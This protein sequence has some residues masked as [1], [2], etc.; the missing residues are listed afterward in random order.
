MKGL[1]LGRMRK[2]QKIELLTLDE[3]VQI[4]GPVE[5]TEEVGDVKYIS[6]RKV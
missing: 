4:L 3:V 5:E 2:T 1:K 6:D